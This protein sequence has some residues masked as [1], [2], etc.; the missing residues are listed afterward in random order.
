MATETP[1]NATSNSLADAAFRRLSE[2]AQTRSLA[3]E[4]AEQERR[5]TFRRLVDPGIMRPN[6]QPQALESLRTIHKLCQNL[7]NDPENPKFQRIKT[8]NAKI[9]KDVIE[10]KGTVEFLRELGFRPEVEEFQPYYTF[11]PSRIN[12]LRIGSKIIEDALK[13]HTEKEERVAATRKAEKEAKE[14]AAEKVKLAFMDDR[15]SRVEMDER[16]RQRR[17]ARAALAAQQAEHDRERGHEPTLQTQDEESEH[18]AGDNSNDD[19]E[20]DDEGASRTSGLRRRTMPGVGH[21]L[22][23]PPPYNESD[24]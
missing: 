8:T 11:N 5:Q 9:K 15:K 12:D 2:A 23:D 21:S 16:E 22:R 4:R 13:L 7:L 10:P 3:E 24:N 6:A 19:E 14:Q 18:A 20:D 17:E 1:T